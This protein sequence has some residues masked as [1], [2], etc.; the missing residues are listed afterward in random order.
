MGYP[1]LSCRSN[2]VTVE[3]PEVPIALRVHVLMVDSFKFIHDHGLVEGILRISGS[4]KRIKKLS[5]SE[6]L[7]WFHEPYPLPHDISGVL[8]GCLRSFDNHDVPVNI[9]YA[10]LVSEVR[11]L[12]KQ[13]A[14]KKM[15]EEQDASGTDASP[16]IIEAT[17][18]ETTQTAEAKEDVTET[19]AK[20][21]EPLAAEPLAAELATEP[22]PTEPSQVHEPLATEV[23][24]NPEPEEPTGQTDTKVVSD[25]VPDSV[26]DSVSHVRSVLD[27]SSPLAYITAESVL[28]SD[29]GSVMQGPQVQFYRQFAKLVCSKWSQSRLHVFLFVV[30]Q[31]HRLLAQREVTK[32]SST[33]LSI[34]FQPYLLNSNLIELMTE[35][36]Q[37]LETIIEDFPDF[38][39]AIPLYSIESSASIITEMSQESVTSH[40]SSASSTES[41][42]SPY[43]NNTSPLK[44]ETPLF[45]EFKRRLNRFSF[46]FDSYSSPVS[47][48]FS[49]DYFSRSK[50]ITEPITE[51]PPSRHLPV[52]HTGNS[53]SLDQVPQLRE[54][55]T[56]KQQK[57]RSILNL[58]SLP[59]TLTPELAAKLESDIELPKRESRTGSRSGLDGLRESF[60]KRTF[61]MKRRP[62]MKQRHTDGSVN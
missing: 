56:T 24:Q 32:M 2:K 17:A 26:P 15:V 40:V 42:G 48:R 52:P 49:V 21:P 30:C 57:R 25:S 59:Y 45:D 58:F 50:S 16:E 31:L 11:R 22:L 43:T 36:Q 23:S 51:S 41:I 6:S 61:S 39:D 60:F 5:E 3:L 37:I 55:T 19:E 14:D 34:I 9:D 20:A 1:Y 53:I 54:P 29:A 10:R 7:L 33:N 12:K 18:N 4:V 44:V 46:L 35:L 28:P 47:K 62:S 38:V 8:K 27:Q 13:E